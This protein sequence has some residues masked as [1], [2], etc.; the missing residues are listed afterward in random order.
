MI[1]A[2]ESRQRC[3][4]MDESS[5]PSENQYPK[6]AFQTPLFLKFNFNVPSSQNKQSRPPQFS[7]ISSNYQLT[8][9]LH[10]S[11]EPSF[12]SP[13]PNHPRDFS[14]IVLPIGNCPLYGNGPHRTG[15][16]LI[17]G[18]C[19]ND[20]TSFAAQIMFPNTNRQSS[21]RLSGTVSSLTIAFT[22]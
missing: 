9:H 17:N 5:C 21:Q 11:A 13:D 1:L 12:P 19:V 10:Q 8:N 6:I 18:I 15:V 4:N 3:S 16:P 7:I 14:R 22:D 2:L 20:Q